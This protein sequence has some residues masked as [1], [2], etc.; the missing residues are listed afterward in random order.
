MKKIAFILSFVLIYASTNAQ[1]LSNSD[2]K[3]CGKLIEEFHMLL[4][5]NSTIY[6]GTIMKDDSTGETMRIVWDEKT[7]S[8]DSIIYDR[9]EKVFI[10]DSKTFIPD[11]K[12]YDK[13][14]RLNGFL[15]EL[16]DK[17]K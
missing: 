15:D 9:K 10:K 8:V 17:K 7:F 2:V 6:W 5:D 12:F 1:P 3:T 13:L 16:Y 14:I 4:S 11:R